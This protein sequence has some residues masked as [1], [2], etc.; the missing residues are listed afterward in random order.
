[1][2]SLVEK[3]K[4]QLLLEIT[5]NQ[6]DYNVLG[7]WKEILICSN[8]LLIRETNGRWFSILSGIN[9]LNPT[10]IELGQWG[11]ILQTSVKLL[12][13]D[14]KDD[15]SWW[16]LWDGMI[17]SGMGYGELGQFNELLETVFG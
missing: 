17:R 2:H 12:R 1:L 3:Q 16:E 6:P 14:I 7:Q 8:D 15:D 11:E 9:N 10:Y 13:K 5:K 4:K